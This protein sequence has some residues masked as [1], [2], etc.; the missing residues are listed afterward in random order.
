MKDE[1]SHEFRSEREVATR[2]WQFGIRDALIALFWIGVIC[3]I[4]IYFGPEGLFVMVLLLTVSYFVD[5]SLSRQTGW[6]EVLVIFFTLGMLFVLFR[7][8]C[9]DAREA[10][11]RNGCLSNIRHIGLALIN[12]EKQYG[13]FPPAYIADRQ[14][15]PMHSWRVLILPQL[16]ENKLY[17]QYRFDE[18]WDGPNNSKLHDQM[19]DYFRCPSDFYNERGNIT[20]YVAVVGDETAWPG[21]RGRRISEIKDDPSQ[22]ALVVEVIDSGIHWMQPDDLQFKSMSMEINYPKGSGVSNAISSDHAS[23]IALMVLID[24][25][26][27]ACG[28]IMDDPPEK[29][30]A[31]LTID[32]GERLA[33]Q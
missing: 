12:Y 14:G 30:R 1:P 26:G 23:G 27:R 28:G 16:G 18:P 5:K 29:I 15:K 21:Q 22:T 3:A 31:M 19:P 20:N 24:G 7:P 32:G 4:V 10:A 33:N 8:A 17:K 13:S 25:T 9:G 6:L 11:R 2:S